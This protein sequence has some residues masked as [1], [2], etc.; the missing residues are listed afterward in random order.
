[1]T[2]SNLQLTVDVKTNLAKVTCSYCHAANYE[3][4][5]ECEK[6]G[7]PLPAQLVELYPHGYNNQEWCTTDDPSD[8]EVAIFELK[9][10]MALGM[11]GIT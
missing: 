1:M 5:L 11:W 2:S 9:K 7:A 4:S 3:L 8:D 10:A 6:C